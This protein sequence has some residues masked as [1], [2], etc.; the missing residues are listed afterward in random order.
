MLYIV[1]RV[2]VVVEKSGEK[3]YILALFFYEFT[4]HWTEELRFFLFFFVFIA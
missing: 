2:C 1:S 3:G 4:I